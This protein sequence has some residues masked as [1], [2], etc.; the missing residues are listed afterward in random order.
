M[1]ELEH[2][3]LKVHKN[4]HTFDPFSIAKCKGTI[5]PGFWLE[6]DYKNTTLHLSAVID[7]KYWNSINN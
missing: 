7:K 2:P 5:Q 6:N 4:G 1:S 3:F